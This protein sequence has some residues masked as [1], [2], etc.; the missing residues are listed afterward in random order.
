MNGND[1]A[2]ALEQGGHRYMISKSEMSKVLV[3]YDHAQ[4][5]LVALAL[6]FGTLDISIP[7]PTSPA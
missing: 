2:G 4:M 5:C 3:V 6:S 1:F 7:I